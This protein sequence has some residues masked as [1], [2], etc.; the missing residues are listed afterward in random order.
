MIRSSLMARFALAL[1]IT[2]PL[3]GCGKPKTPTAASAVASEAR[4]VRVAKVE[5]R[6]M[7]GGIAASG[8]L[9]SREEA[10]AGS[11][12]VGY[13]VARVFV[14]EGAVVRQ[15]QALL[16][17]DDTLL[18]AQIDQQRALLDQRA[19]AAQIAQ[20][21]AQRVDGLEGQG[22][23]S[24]EQIQQRR[25]QAANAKAILA[26]QKA[27]LNELLTRQ[28]RLT[29]RAPVSGRVLERT[30][31]PGDVSGGGSYFRIARDGLVEL[32]A[33][34][35]EIDLAKLSVGDQAEVTLSSGKTLTGRVR[36]I[37]PKIDVQSRLGRV[38]IQLPMDADLRP[39]GY[40]KAVF[41]GSARPVRVVPEASVRFDADGA[42][43]MTVAADGKVKQI[44]IKTGQR[45]G[46]F[47]ELIQGPDV[48]QSVVLG[49]ASF[50]INGDT[51]KPYQ[52]ATAAT[53]SAK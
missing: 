13:R 28:A 4:S 14:E 26:A 19:L 31:R 3:A 29:V 7:S 52:A 32:D 42:S 22:V 48:G 8:L 12:L 15:G 16:Q 50:V 34:A 43:L 20:S 27:Q 5:T 30:V 51:V 2:V 18:R 49:A 37:S 24:D 23:L 17:L 10:V 53:T 45:S 44:Q 35:P 6:S 36:L 33:E 41:S 40:A 38:R 9:V 11:E 21:E 47:V 39:G 46:G 25:F 1:L